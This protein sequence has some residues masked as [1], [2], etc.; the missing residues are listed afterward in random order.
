MFNACALYVSVFIAVHC[1]RMST[2]IFVDIIRLTNYPRSALVSIGKNDRKTGHSMP[3][4]DIHV[5]SYRGYEYEYNI[6]H[7]CVVCVYMNEL[8][9]LWSIEIAYYGFSQ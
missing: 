7:K 8:N 6:R 5:S 3:M 9:E 1:I 2:D 4:P